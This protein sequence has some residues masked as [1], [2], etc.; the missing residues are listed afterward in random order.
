[1]SK[2]DKS[3][4]F[5]QSDMTKHTHPYPHIEKCTRASD[6]YDHLE[7]SG[8]LA[9]VEVHSGRK[10]TD[11]ELR[12]VHSAAHVAEVHKMT[13][14][15]LHD[16]NNR[17]LCEPDGPGGIYYSPMAEHCARLACGCVIDVAHHVLHHSG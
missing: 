14:A 7:K 6:C 4:L 12:T 3:A 11:D 8:V 1:M 16:P 15:A 13:Q 2:R 5:Y 10:A 17:E 9:N